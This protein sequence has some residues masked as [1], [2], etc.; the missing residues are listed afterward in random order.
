MTTPLDPQTLNAAMRSYVHTFSRQ[1]LLDAF[2]TANGLS[3][4][5]KEIKRHLDGLLRTA[6]AHLYDYPGGVPWDDE[7][8]RD[9]VV[10]LQHNHTWVDSNTIERV[11]SFS[12]W[13]CWHEGLN[14]NPRA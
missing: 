1:D 4:Y 8:E 9:F 13:L 3:T 6:E 11:L 14:R 2:I 7:F 10:M 12:G 5:R